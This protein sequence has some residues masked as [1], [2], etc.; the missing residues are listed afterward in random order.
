MLVGS[1]V[2]QHHVASISSFDLPL[3]QVES[4][5]V[6]DRQIR[7]FVRFTNMH[8]LYKDKDILN[9]TKLKKIIIEVKI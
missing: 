3:W 8:V 7:L 6:F 9:K 1:A 4:L 5:L 2:L